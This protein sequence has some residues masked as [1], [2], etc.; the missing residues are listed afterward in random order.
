MGIVR[1]NSLAL[2]CGAA[3]GVTAFSGAAQ[4]QEDAP[5]ELAPVVVQSQRQADQPVQQGTETRIARPVLQKRAVDN[6]TDLGR[7]VDAGVNFNTRNNS[8]N[9]RGLQDDRVLTT[10]DG[11]RVPWLVDPRDSARGGLNAFDFDSL[12]ALD[13]LRG[14]DSSRYGSGAL[15]GVVQLRTLDPEDL[16]EEGKNH[17]GIVKGAYD[18]ADRSW[19]ANAAVAGRV[20]DTWLMVQ[21]GYRK[22]HEI[23]NMGTVGG[24]GNTRSEANPEDY[25]QKNFL[26]K[27]HQYVEGGHR[28]GLTGEIFDREDDMLNNTGTTASY[29]PGEFHAIDVTKRNRV[30]AEYNF[31]SPDKSGWLDRANLIAYWQEQQLNAKTD[32]IRQDLTPPISPPTGPFKRDNEL[33]QNAYGLVGDGEKEVLLGELSNNFRFGGEIYRTDLTQYSSGQDNCPAVPPPFSTCSFLGSNHS[34][35]PDV[36]GSSIG[37]FVEDDIQFLGGRLTLTPGVR[38]DY[39]DFSPTSTTAFEASPTYDPAYLVDNSDS[40]FSP[41]LRVNYAATEKLDL[42]AQWAQGFRAPSALELYGN[43]GNFGN[44]VRLGN[45]DL[46]PETSNGF[47]VGFKY[48]GSNYNV[49]LNLFNNYYRD[50]IEEITLV[51]PP[52]GY[53]MGF[54]VANFARAHIYGAEVRGDV[55]I[56]SNWN[57]WGSLALAEGTGEE[58]GGNEFALSSVAPIRA[59]V[60]VGY[61]AE[62]WGA[63]L[64]TTLAAAR[65]GVTGI[66]GNGFQA[67]G[68]GIVDA[69]VW[70][71]PE[72]VKGLKLQAGVFNI[73]DQKYWI[74]TNVPDGAT[75]PADYYTEPGRT[76]RLSLTQKF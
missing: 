62:T 45:P 61:T 5:V 21:G 76:F 15:A 24:Y 3:I 42:F 7:R 67:P 70:W 55:Q 64:S 49:S 34:D 26:A 51:P 69:T 44:Y 43:Y 22:G 46:K 36:D 71:E 29:V 75:L 27:I 12:S 68:Y 39:Y 50:F 32:A 58:E 13:I 14:S 31:E 48:K 52:A 47:E 28:F 18:S 2:V 23:E 11:V 30:S 40:R 54:G 8:I 33:K 1:F 10:I 73:L 53:M 6:F 9:L 74:A 57:A 63:D 4:A 41:K 66:D 37:L 20:N 35:M 56:N 60:G 17:G 19:R 65:K 16:I 38:F 72:Q 59:I 25:D